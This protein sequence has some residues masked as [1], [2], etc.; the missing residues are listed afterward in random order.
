MVEAEAIYR[1][2]VN[3]DMAREMF[4]GPTLAASSSAGVDCSPFGR[5]SGREAVP[6]AAATGEGRWRVPA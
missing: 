5:A 4:G 6:I 2:K 3:T 1:G